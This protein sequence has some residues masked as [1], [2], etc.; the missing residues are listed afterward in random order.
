[1]FFTETV[2]RRRHAQTPHS[3]IVQN[4]GKHTTFPFTRH[5]LEQLTRELR[6]AR[7]TLFS[8]LLHPLKEIREQQTILQ[9]LTRKVETLERSIAEKL[10]IQLSSPQT[11]GTL[12]QFRK[13][14]PLGTVYVDLL[15]YLY[16]QQD[17]K[18]KGLKG[19]TRTPSYV[20]F[21]VSAEKVQRVELGE[22]KP[23]EAAIRQWRSAI[24]SSR[25]SHEILQKRGDRVRQL[26]W[27]KVEKALQSHSQNTHS[28]YLTPDGDLTRLPWERSP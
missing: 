17:P 21:L 1:M 26:I 5:D 25:I 9:Q 28:I 11:R 18:V 19:E 10:K 12:A 15:K 23:I 16:F 3:T 27:D 6:F 7:S 20:A 2:A 8:R 4:K 14:L 13:A 24:T 22:A